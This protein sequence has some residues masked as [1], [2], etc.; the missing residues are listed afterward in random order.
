MACHALIPGFHRGRDILVADE[1]FGIR[2][3][4]GFIVMDAEALG[5]A[6]GFH[7]ASVA[8]RSE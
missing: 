1:T 4:G 2:L 8:N 3:A 7:I 6:S 5:V